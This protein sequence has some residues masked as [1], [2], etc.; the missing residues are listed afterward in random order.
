[1]KLKKFESFLPPLPSP[2]ELLF[3]SLGLIYV[4]YMI[5]KYLKNKYRNYRDNKKL[6]KEKLLGIVSEIESEA[7]KTYSNIDIEESQL[8]ID[9]LRE[10]IDSKKIK[11]INE[12]E[13]YF[14]NLL[15]EL[16]QHK[17]Y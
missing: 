9:E 3:G 5:S 15:E 12:L 2:N 10:A 13:C 11:T 8:I 16:K 14:K 4:G 17:K 7:I 6:T 1:M